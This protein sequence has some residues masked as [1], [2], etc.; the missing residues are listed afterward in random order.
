M[1]GLM[2][3]SEKLSFRVMGELVA[4]LGCTLELE[5]YKSMIG[6]NYA[7][8]VEKLAQMFPSVADPEHEILIPFTPVYLERVAKGELEP[9]KGLFE[10]L[11]ELEARGIKKAVASSNLPNVVKS[12]LSQVGAYSRMDAVVT[13]GMVKLGKPAPDLFLKAAEL[14]CANADECL[15]LEDSPAGILAAEA[16]GMKAIMIPD[17]V[18]PSGEIRSKCM[19]VYDSLLDVRDYIRGERP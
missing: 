17:M 4:K 18:P 15:V 13:D 1:D 10:L 8:T 12:C 11:D 9:K 5:G 3:D 7:S 19:K 2:V 6:H 14:L 16:A